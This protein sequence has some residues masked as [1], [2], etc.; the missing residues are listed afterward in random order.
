[1][2]KVLPRFQ[3]LIGLCFFLVSVAAY[4]ESGGPLSPAQAAY[5]VNYYE[6]DLTIN[7]T[8]KTISGSLLCRV[9]IVNSIDTLVLDLDDPF[10][11]DSILIS[12][13]DGSFSIAGFAHSDG[14][15][16]NYSCY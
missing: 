4:A 12:I 7:L 3:L 13:N 8:T 16:N 15:T 1:M 11:I 9:E 14:R 6:L 5:D 2:M 10:T